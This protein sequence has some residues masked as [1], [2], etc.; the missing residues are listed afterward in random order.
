MASSVDSFIISVLPSLV[1]LVTNNV[2]NSGHNPAG[3]SVH[4]M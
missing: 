1:T 4:A 3:N 2:I